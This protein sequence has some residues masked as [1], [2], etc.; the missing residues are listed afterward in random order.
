MAYATPAQM[1]IRYDERTLSELVADDNTAVDLG[2]LNTDTNLLAMLDDASGMVDAALLTGGLYTAAQLSGLTGNA[3]ALLVRLTCHLAFT[4]LEERRN[5]P[6]PER[7]DKRHDWA[8][9][10]LEK[11][12]KGI[13]L[14]GLDAHI[15]ASKGDLSHVTSTTVDR[16]NLVRDR[17]HHFYPQRTYSRN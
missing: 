13:N 11:L 10:Q 1:R 15:A 6:D 2:D 14:F 8:E 4:L 7:F 16:A 3:A 9:Q 17:T 12:R 5:G